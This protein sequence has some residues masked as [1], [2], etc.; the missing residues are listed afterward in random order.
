MSGFRSSFS[1]AGPRYLSSTSSSLRD[2]VG[3]LRTLSLRV[4]PSAEFVLPSA[5]SSGMGCKAYRYHVG[6]ATKVAK[7][8]PA[9]EL[10]MD[11]D[12]RVGFRFDEDQ[13]RISTR[14][15]IAHRDG[16]T[17]V[18]RSLLTVVRLAPLQL[19]V[20]SKRGREKPGKVPR[21]PCLRLSRDRSPSTTSKRRQSCASKWF[22]VS[23]PKVLRA[24]PTK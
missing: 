12:Q 15:E 13:H 11:N 24:N 21:Y 16:F 8:A 6:D 3:A 19:F 10:F 18:L 22:L 7:A 20:Q 17:V 14:A 4:Q 5:Q 2:L 1:G 9:G 23:A